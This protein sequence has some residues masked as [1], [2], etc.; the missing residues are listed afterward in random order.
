M[1][2]LSLDISSS[3]IGR[4]YDGQP[5]ATWLLKQRC[6]AERCRFAAALLRGQLLETPDIDLIVVESPVARFGGAVIA[7][8]RV[9]GALLAVVSEAGIAWCELAPQKAKKALTGHGNAKKPAMIL[10]A[11]QQV[12]RMLDEHQADAYGL[13]LA[14]LQV[15]IE[16]V[17]A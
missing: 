1:N 10:A 7:Q 16:K 2:I 8:A 12:G 11:S 5:G 13:W 6:I 3:H 17:A 14:A 9:S 15:R 4:C